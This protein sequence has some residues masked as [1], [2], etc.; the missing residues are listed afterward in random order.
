M[1]PVVWGATSLLRL[2][3]GVTPTTAIALGLALLATLNLGLAF[4][5]AHRLP[6]SPL[7][8]LL[9][10]GYYALFLSA[11]IGLSIA[12]SYTISSLMVLLV[13]YVWLRDPAPS[14]LGGCLRLGGAVGLAGLCNT[15]FLLLAGPPAMH[16]L[17]AA[18]LRR[19]LWVGVPV[20][21]HG[22]SRGTDP[23]R[24]EVR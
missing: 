9:A 3:P 11:L 16:V 1:G 5:V 15:P 4:L 17:L 21:R 8:A 12:D 2:I 23:C 20:L 6:A 14:D 18:D 7:I 24:A 13:L 22:R 19:S 10:T